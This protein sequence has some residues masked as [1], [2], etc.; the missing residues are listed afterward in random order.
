MV[1]TTSSRTAERKGQT[2]RIESLIAKPM[3]LALKNNH[4]KFHKGLTGQVVLSMRNIRDSYTRDRRSIEGRSTHQAT[5]CGSKLAGGYMGTSTVPTNRRDHISNLRPVMAPLGSSVA[6]GIT[7]IL[8]PP[9]GTL[10]WRDVVSRSQSRPSGKFPSLK[11]G[12]MLQWESR[13]ELNAFRLLD[14]NPQINAFTEQ[15]CRIEYT[16]GGVATYHVPDI[17]VEVDGRKELWEIKPNSEA[18]QPEIAART[19]VMSQHLP[20]WGYVYRVVLADDLLSQ[21]RLRNANRLLQFGR[22]HVTE[23][24][25]ESIRL[26][27]KQSGRLMWSS[28][29]DGNYGARG[30]QILCRM[31]IDGTLSIDLNEIWSAGTE[32]VVENGGF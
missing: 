16:I 15:P 2:A 13:N 25:Q 8:F 18:T 5:S 31:V 22:D 14:S 21:P 9:V 12:R 4:S 10:R 23:C 32:F 19:V 29:C 27:L 28:A 24:E 3:H 26:A 6:S 30:R 1:T 20:T 7:S 11:M 17:L